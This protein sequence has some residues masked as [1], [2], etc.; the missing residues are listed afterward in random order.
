M[1]TRPL[2]QSGIEASVVGL[3]AWAIGGWMWGGTDEAESIRAIHASI[4]AGVNLIDTAAIYGFGLSE[5]IVGNAIRDRRDRVVLATKCSMVCNP[6]VG[7][8]KFR[9][10]AQG[11]DP[12]GH[13]TIHIHSAPDSI[14]RE[15]EAS[16]KRLRTD[17]IDLYQTHWQESITPIEETMGCLMDLKR[18]GKIR[19]IGACNATVEQL[20]RYRAAGQL[21]ADQE[22]YSMLDRKLDAEQLPYCLEHGVAVLAYS[23]L[24]RGLLTGKIGPEREFKEGDLRRADLRFARSN[25]QKAAEMLE[26]FKPVAEKHG[27]S[28]G[29]LVIAWTVRQPGLTHALCGARNPSQAEENA[30]AGRAE[31]PPEDLAAI[32]A[33]LAEYAGKVR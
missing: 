12:D 3:G 31:L 22:L 7:E 5:S 23:P 26:R 14:R 9:S 6:T 20:E 8:F 11:P 19:A 32:D 1:Q 29:Q 24:A 28:L 17:R 27:L 16:L 33:A 21:D 30:A 18:E 13:V 2:G 25:R 4:D 15:L 10:S